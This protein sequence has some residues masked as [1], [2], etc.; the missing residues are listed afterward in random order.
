MKYKHLLL[1]NAAFALLAGL[2]LAFAPEKMMDSL[3]LGLN[4][5]AW[6][7]AHAAAALI[8]ASGLLCWMSRDLSE[9]AGRRAVLA[10]I[11]CAHGLTALWGASFTLNGTLNSNGWGDVTVHGAFAIGAAY[12]LLR[13]H[14]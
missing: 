9:A 3:G 7:L 6:H 13:K 2:G 12:L 11:L 1:A 14:A 5:A 10:S 4:P 8:F